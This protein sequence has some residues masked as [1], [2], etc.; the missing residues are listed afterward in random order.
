MITLIEKHQEA[1]G[2]HM[3]YRHPFAGRMTMHQMLIFLNDHMAHHIKQINRIVSKI[4]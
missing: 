4:Y 2:S 3:V 1:F